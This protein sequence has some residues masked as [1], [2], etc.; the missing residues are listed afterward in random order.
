M[1]RRTP[2]VRPE[3]EVED[4]VKGDSRGALGGNEDSEESGG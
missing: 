3:L 2:L 4:G 1:I